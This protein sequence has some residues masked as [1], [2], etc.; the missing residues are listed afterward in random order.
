MTRTRREVR[1][2]PK[3]GRIVFGETIPCTYCKQTGTY[4]QADSKKV[5][6]PHCNA[7][8]YRAWRANEVDG[9]AGAST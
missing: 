5:P 3:L 1:I 8:G 4:I 9:H 7:I 2:Q 6:C